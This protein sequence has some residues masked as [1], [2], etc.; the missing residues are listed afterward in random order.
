MGQG[1]LPS[2]SFS[3]AVTGHLPYPRPLPE[4]PPQA[5]PPPLAARPRH[6]PY[7][8]AHT[9]TADARHQQG[10]L[11]HPDALEEQHLRPPSVV[12]ALSYGKHALP[13]LR[14]Q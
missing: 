4:A 11:W 10:V 13:P 1:P 7:T 5:L 12:D 3:F 6:L 8:L 9:A 2:S 14:A